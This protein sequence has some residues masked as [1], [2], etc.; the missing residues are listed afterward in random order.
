MKTNG[1]KST[2]E[3]IISFVLS[4]KEF[5][6]SPSVLN[7]TSLALSAAK[8]GIQDFAPYFEEII[9]EFG[10]HILFDERISNIIIDCLKGEEKEKI[11]FNSSSNEVIFKLKHYP[12]CWLT[13]QQ[14]N[15]GKGLVTAIYVH[16]E[17]REEFLSYVREIAWDKYRKNNLVVFSRRKENHW[18]IE[19]DKYINAQPSMSSSRLADDIKKFSAANIPRSILLWGKPGTGKSTAVREIC[20]ILEF[21]YLRFRVEQ[22][23][24]FKTES[25][26]YLIELFNP[27]AIIVDDFDRTYEQA[28][29][30]ETLELF[31]AKG[32]KCFMATVND[33]DK[34]DAAV[35]RPGRID[36][37][38]QFEK[39]DEEAIHT[40]LQSNGYDDVFEEVKEW[41]VAYIQ[42]Y[43]LRRKILGKER[44][45]E[46]IQQL[47]DRIDKLSEGKVESIKSPH[48]AKAINFDDFSD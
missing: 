6:R 34:L 22:M 44:A 45:T 12:V 29:L 21:R 30:L 4:A 46:S 14:A 5:K 31:H 15:N 25:M 8:I 11:N 18:H 43:C 48:R 13:N 37:I 3:S 38:V 16:P 35:V 23:S 1:W 47:S 36:E 42:E 20:Q 33:L 19:E 39:L 9:N 28:E 32:V 2:V 17:Y 24:E 10:Y 41:P 7:A 26:E 27:E 40:I